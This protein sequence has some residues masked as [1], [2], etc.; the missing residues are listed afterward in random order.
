MSSISEFYELLES[1]GVNTGRKLKTDRSLPK[2]KAQFANELQLPTL[3]TRADQ[4][5]QAIKDQGFVKRI[6]VPE[7]YKAQKALV[8]KL[9][10]EF[11]N[12]KLTQTP[13]QIIVKYSVIKKN[14][15]DQK[16]YLSNLPK[17]EQIKY[18]DLISAKN[19][20]HNNGL[21]EKKFI[22]PAGVI[23]NPNSLKNL[24]AE[25]IKEWRDS[26]KAGLVHDGVEDTEGAE[27]VYI[28]DPT[29]KVGVNVGGRVN[30]IGRNKVP[31]FHQEAL[32]YFSVNTGELQ[33]IKSDYNCVIESFIRELTPHQ[34]KLC[35]KKKLF[36]EI[37]F[38]QL[39]IQNPDRK[40]T[41][42]IYIDDCEI[43]ASF[44]NVSFYGI[45]IDGNLIKKVQ[46]ARNVKS[47]A[48]ALVFHDNHAYHMTH[49][50]RAKFIKYYMKTIHYASKK[51]EVDNSEEDSIIS[52]VNPPINT[53]PEL[54]SSKLPDAY[55][56]IVLQNY[57]GKALTHNLSVNN[58]V[59]DYIKK[60]KKMASF[61]PAPKVEI[62]I[63][64]NLEYSQE[65]SPER[66]Y[67]DFGL[68]IKE[69]SE[70]FYKD[71]HPMCQYN[72]QTLQ[73]FKFS[74]N[75]KPIIFRTPDWCQSTHAYDVNKCYTK[76]FSEMTEYPYF[77]SDDIQEPFSLPIRP[78]YL[79][80]LPDTTSESARSPARRGWNLS[81]CL[82]NNTP[83]FQL[84]FET[85][86]MNSK[87]FI[88]ELYEKYP[89]SAKS[90]INRMIG[91]CNR[92][93]TGSEIE[94]WFHSID[95]LIPYWDDN[96]RSIF[97]QTYMGHDG[98]SITIN[99]ETEI[100][101]NRSL[102]YFHIISNAR[103]YITSLIN[104]ANPQDLVGCKTDCIYFKNPQP[105]LEKLMGP[106][107]GQLK[108][109]SP[110]LDDGYLPQ[111][112]LHSPIP[113]PIEVPE[114][115]NI[116][117]E[118]VEQF[119]EQGNSCGVWGDGGT[120][121]SELCK[122]LQSKMPDAIILSF[123]H[124]ALSHYDKSA[125][126]ETLHS[127]FGLGIMG[128][129]SDEIYFKVNR[130]QIR[131]AI[132]EEVSLMPIGFDK[133]LF[134][135]K[136]M[137]IQIILA[138]DWLQLPADSCHHRSW[139][140]D[141]PIIHNLVDNNQCILTKNYRALD[142][143]EIY[144]KCKENEGKVN[145]LNEKDVKFISFKESLKIDKHIC[146]SNKKC[147][148]INN[149]LVKANGRGKT[150]Y[151]GL[152]II[153]TSNVSIL[154]GQDSLLKNVFGKVFEVL[155]TGVIVK[156]DGIDLEF[157]EE[158]YTNNFKVAYASTYHKI[159]GDSVREPFVLHDSTT[160]W[161][162]LWVGI[163]RAGK[164]EFINIVRVDDIPVGIEL[165]DGTNPEKPIINYFSL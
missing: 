16:Y 134:D 68:H 46:P 119:I 36:P 34:E 142:L 88:T 45:D 158:E 111:A 77:T 33:A 23:D 58:F 128:E 161:T 107:P 5:I 47:Y 100:T 11:N 38:K 41:D 141:T 72:E 149:L 63:N 131:I 127:Y 132:I 42:G 56:K 109:A 66:P 90:I 62:V 78:N 126:R 3:K 10:T 113:N 105:A 124:K 87:K 28:S 6:K 129:N 139:R 2:L 94:R 136:Q 27:D 133:Y 84:H 69:I 61:R 137:G 121:K 92:W 108:R 65:I 165:K 104:L 144:D 71:T 103:K 44:L 123:T 91:I 4:L 157:T 83:T 43:I 79:Y 8:Q 7:T 50:K 48:V 163:T 117:P 159:Q 53:I 106:L 82:D 21:R 145:F 97:P 35:I 154:G 148:Y 156:I 115:N 17:A 20:S 59:P 25:K 75:L 130:R 155:P 120:G 22:I 76:M 1:R 31:Y 70:G 112:T 162:C 151:P 118:E 15:A 19:A 102:L 14:E 55:L 146:Y 89:K 64:E 152:P 85:V 13:T 98:Y 153:T 9:T 80:F 39:T 67:K 95:D 51:K 32:N 29:Y 73:T 160:S 122:K 140:K 74:S 164:R 86:P 143:I 150:V 57:P 96:N 110:A 12:P 135:M 101:L 93:H 37:I 54:I 40:I 52:I 26:L 116:L 30:K 114:W 24:S 81:S 60:Y 49:E 125:H 18:D 147:D 138:G 99:T